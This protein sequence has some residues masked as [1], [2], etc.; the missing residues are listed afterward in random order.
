MSVAR[1][2]VFLTVRAVGREVENICKVASD[3]C[4]LK[5]VDKLVRAGEAADRVKLGVHNNIGQKIFGRL[6][7]V[8][9]RDEAIAE[10]VIAEH[11]LPYFLALTLADIDLTLSH[12]DR[13]K[14]SY[15]EHIKS[16]V[17][18]AFAA[19]H[20]NFLTSASLDFQPDNTAYVFSEIINIAVV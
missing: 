6:I 9:T 20:N 4:V 13:L 3:S 8:D 18:Q 12:S 11:R 2:A 5:L 7:L 17:K 10:T 16:A 19:G 1:P 15:I 14:F